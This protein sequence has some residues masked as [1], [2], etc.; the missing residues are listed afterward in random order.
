MMKDLNLKFVKIIHDLRTFIDL[1]YY[2]KNVI[3]IY[4]FN[5][6]YNANILIVYDYL[7]FFIVCNPIGNNSENIGE[8]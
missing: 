4:N 5:V 2:F 7:S 6:E 1:I 8:T 3:L